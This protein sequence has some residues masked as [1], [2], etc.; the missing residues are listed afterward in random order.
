MTALHTKQ[1][2]GLLIAALSGAVFAL[3]LAISGMTQPAKVQ[4][5]LDITGQWQPALAFV[6]GGALGVYALIYWAVVRRMRS[7][8]LAARFELPTRTRLDRKLLLG[9]SLFG[10][11]WGLSGFCPGPALV[12]APRALLS[13]PSGVMVFVVAMLAGMGLFELMARASRRDS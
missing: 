1:A 12:S 5:F 8:A 11:G 9:A 2:A 6:M 13:G 7:P 10:A 3:G 4:G